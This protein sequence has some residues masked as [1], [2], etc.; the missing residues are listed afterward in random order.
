MK[1]THCVWMILIGLEPSFTYR[2]MRRQTVGI[3]LQIFSQ[4]SKDSVPVDHYPGFHIDPKL[5]ANW[6]SFVFEG[7]ASEF[8]VFIC[9]ESVKLA[10]CWALNRSLIPTMVLILG[11]SYASQVMLVVSRLSFIRTYPSFERSRSFLKDLALDVCRSVLMLTV[12]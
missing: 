10:I 12:S 4:F 8:I 6:N 3:I 5:I 2:E 7:Q 9:F 11:P 1:N